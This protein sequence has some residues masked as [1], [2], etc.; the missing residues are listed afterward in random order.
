MRHSRLMN[1]LG[2]AATDFRLPGTDG[3]IYS[4]A[5]AAGS[6]GL[7]VAF[8][9]NH[10]PFVL[11]ILDRFVAIAAEYARKGFFTIAISSNDV[12]TFP[13]DG[14]QKMAELARARGFGFPYLYDESQTVAKSYGAACTPD[15]FLFDAQRRLYYRGQFDDSR[16]VT[17]HSQ[18]ERTRIPVTG[19]D[20]C[21]AIDALLAGLPAPAEQRA[22]T[23]CSMKWRAGNEPD[24][25]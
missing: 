18:G 25:A 12:A 6:R 4:L 11:H 16:P 1:P 5:D 2:Q 8:I 7:L 19:K 17:P 23:G 10:C 24:W 9:C 13:E 15:L 3:K 20:L 14:P 21:A 22:S